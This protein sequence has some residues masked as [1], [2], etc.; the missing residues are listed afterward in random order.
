MNG[1]PKPPVLDAR[2]LLVSRIVS[3]VERVENLIIA[4][5][6]NFP[7]GTVSRSRGS[8]WFSQVSRDE[9]SLRPI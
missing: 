6:T 9:G 8:T 2:E 4:S 7:G 3:V 5:I 1:R